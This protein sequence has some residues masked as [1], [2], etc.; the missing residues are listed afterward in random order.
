MITRYLYKLYE[1]MNFL[2]INYE[3]AYPK[4]ISNEK[5]DYPKGSR[6]CKN[7]S[8]SVI[9]NETECNEE[10][11]LLGRRDSSTSLRMTSFCFFTFLHS[12]DPS[13]KSKIYRPNFKNYGNYLPTASL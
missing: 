1:S 8:E 2:L 10:S 13:G 3:T 7:V 9:L 5:K 12:L 4:G 11:R 6:L